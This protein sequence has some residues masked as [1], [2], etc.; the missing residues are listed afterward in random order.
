MAVPVIVG[1]ALFKYLAGEGVRRLGDRRGLTA[2]ELVSKSFL[3][4][5]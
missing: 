2:A 4:C 3:G 5:Y 1:C